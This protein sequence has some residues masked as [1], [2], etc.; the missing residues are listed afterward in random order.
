MEGRVEDNG[1]V[2]RG[3]AIRQRMNDH[4]RVSPQGIHFD[5]LGKTLIYFVA[6]SGMRRLIPSSCLCV[7]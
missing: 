4:V 2:R 5:I 1:S 7:D 3:A 6:K